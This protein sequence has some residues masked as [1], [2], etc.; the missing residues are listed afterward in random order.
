[1]KLT[2]FSDLQVSTET[3]ED[4][5]PLMQEV[6]RIV[7]QV[8]ETEPEKVLPDTHIFFDLGATSIQYFSILTALAERFSITEYEKGDSYRYTPREICRYLERYL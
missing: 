2:A 8:L 3:Q 4:T 6:C 7:A 1:M 5:S